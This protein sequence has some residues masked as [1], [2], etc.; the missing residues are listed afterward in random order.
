LGACDDPTHGTDLRPEGPPDVLAVL[1]ATDAANHLAETATYCRSGDA[2]RPGLVGLPDFTTSQ[3]CPDDG[4]DADKV[5]DAYPDGWYIRVMFDELLDPSVETLDEII[6]DSGEPTG[7]FTGSIATTQPVK[8][9]CQTATGTAFVNVDY[10]GYYSPAGNAVTW[11]LGPSLVIKPNDPTLIAT[12]KE[13]RITLNS[14]IT[15]KDGNAVPADQIGPYT[16]ETSKIA[17]IATDPSDSG[18]A[19]APAAVDAFAPY[20][21]NFYYQFNTDVLASSF[22]VDADNPATDYGAGLCDGGTEQFTLMP[23]AL[24]GVCSQSADVN[25]RPVLCDVKSDCPLAAEHC[26]SAYVYTYS[27]VTVDDEIGIGW[28]SPLE[29]EKDY[30]F[31]LKPGAKLKDRCGNE[32]T[33][34]TPSVDNLFEINFKTN[35]FAMK[36]VNIADGETA[37]MVKKITLPFTNYVDGSSLAAT[38]YSINPVPAGFLVGSVN[39][40]EIII[41]G[42]YAPATEYTFTL[43]AGATIA[44]VY[45]KVHTNTAAKTI[46]WK[47][48]PAVLLTTATADNT[49]IQK[50]ATV[51]PVGVSLSF[52]A[53]MDITT[54]TAADF[55]F[56]NKAGTAVAGLAIGVGS[57]AA[58]QDCS[59]DASS[60]C[61][62]RVRAD[63][64]P[65]TYT[66]T[67]KKDAQ[68]KDNLGN[69][70]TQ[71]ADRV[72]HLT[73]KAP[74]APVQ[75]L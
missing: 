39:G 19:D 61:Q 71:A 5:T 26:D 12:G 25:G 31:T 68:M 33:V 48:A 14:N 1:V 3:I 52:N 50:I 57:S 29:A 10:D 63:L 49:V 21:D 47:T 24:G 38:E 11:P 44:D 37:A 35:K 51:Q 74:A 56:V 9:E 43:N 70:Y 32:T 69:T 40:N 45:G 62:F 13:C 6:D 64:P 41:G 18:D 55:T 65:D 27:G 46:K 30:K 15:D 23:P 22:C 20:F 16:F 58:G 53:N 67:L 34:A 42:N 59:P 7:T 75:C 72:I 66:F 28:I 36:T 2:K 4:T 54:F 73:V 8:L 17:L 60:G